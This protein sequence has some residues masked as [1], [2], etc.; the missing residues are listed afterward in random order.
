MKFLFVLQYP[1]YL[2]YFDS[3]IRLLAERG[4]T[5]ALGFD[6]PHKQPEGAEALAGAV[7][8]IEWLDRVPVRKGVWNVVGKGVRGTIDFARYLHPDFHDAPY[9][10]DRMRHALPWMTRLL[11]R[12]DTWSEPATR[13]LLRALDAL[14]RAMPPSDRL[15][16]YLRQVGPDAVIVSP[17]VTDRC[18]QVDFIK[19]ARVLGIP[20]ALGVASW[21]H[22]T[23]KGLMRIQPDLVTVW[24]PFQ[25]D[26]A[27][28]Y[29]GADPDRILVSGAQNFDRWFDRMPSRDRETFC[30]QVGLDPAAPIV[31]FVGS[32]ASISAPEAEVEFVRGWV[33]ALRSGAGGAL[34]HAGVLIRPHPYNSAHW[35]DV[36]LSDVPNAAVFPLGGSNP[37]NESDRADY[38]DS[39]YH[40]AAVVGVNTSAMIEAAIVG[41]TV[42]TIVGDEF[43]DTQG[44]TLHFRYLLPANG[45]FLRVARTLDEHVAQVVETLGHPEVGRQETRRFVEAFIRPR[46][47][48]V[49]ATPVVA[50][51]LEA[52]ARGRTTESAR[53]PA[54]LYPVRFALWLIGFVAVYKAPHRIRRRAG[55]WIT[56]RRRRAERLREKREHRLKRELREERRR[57]TG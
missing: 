7:G 21:D 56:A 28:K 47:L 22:L 45:G 11:R 40:S 34:A 20:N 51:A 12:S 36:D 3:V 50:D 2:R 18:P 44:G 49:D 24:N 30:R 31:L 13:R 16:H 42:H 54:R 55:E 14:E 37:V 27:V 38:F 57:R 32:T 35:G 1:G 52:L 6:S 4:H 43:R 8:D 41:R 15:V 9:L 25:K 46:G 5:V 26:E 33:R 19:A 53:V 29:H 48:E 10:R 17:L 39:L 23:T